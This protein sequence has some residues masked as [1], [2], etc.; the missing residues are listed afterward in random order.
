M[1]SASRSAWRAVWMFVCSR[2]SHCPLGAAALSLFFVVLA[3]APLSLA[4]VLAS[5]FLRCVFQ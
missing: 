2:R 4:P 5:F 3:L 1:D